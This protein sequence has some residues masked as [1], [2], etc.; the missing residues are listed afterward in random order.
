MEKNV[1]KQKTTAPAGKKAPSKSR[2]TKKKI[3]RTVQD[4]LDW[5]CV[6]ENGV[7]QIEP[8]KFSKS[9]RFDDASFK[10]LSDEEQ[11]RI[12]ES[13][14]KF[15]NLMQPK[16]DLFFTFHNKKEDEK[17]KLSRVLPQ[18]RGD[19]LN[20][21]RDEISEILQENMKLSRN[22]ISTLR[23]LTIT[24]E[25]DNVDDAMRRLNTLTGE[26]QNNFK[27]IADSSLV[28]FTL[29]ERLE[30]LN[31]ILNGIEK[32]YWFIH[33]ERGNVSIDFDRM[34]KHGY[35]TKDIIAPS[36]LKFEGSRFLIGERYGQAMYLDG[37]SNWGD[38]NI[39]P[40]IIDVNFESVF[41][42]HISVLDQQDAI[43][44]IHNQ[45]VNITGELQGK[46][47]HALSNGRDPSFVA[48][49]LKKA[50]EQVDELQDDI[51]N[52]DQRLFFMS[53]CVTH[54]ADDEEELKNQSQTIKNLAAKHMCSIKP[55]IMQQERGL[56]SSL[57]IGHDKLFV[58]RLLTTES[59]G[60]FLPFDEVNQ[61][62][63]GG[64]YYGI[65]AINK[66]LIVYD[67]KNYPIR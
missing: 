49:D 35:T 31:S 15:L 3:P 18:H 57:P 28:E 23:Y 54:F 2:N 61:F 13:Y 42:M 39:I 60:V 5:I 9:F 10:T 41:T 45:S 43:K 8:K 55:L 14:M 17:Q 7:F 26:L 11:D 40:D 12:Y 20:D 47:E 36:A 48:M 62:D 27:K 24:I 1:N 29:A 53:L 51:A 38:S 46:Q 44:K 22:C 66:S 50:K 30:V 65:N 56:L 37:L 59:L 6:F 16:E 67:R 32:N 33:D 34:A 52:R 21:L 63:D 58:N 19:N 4:T 25:S 64:I